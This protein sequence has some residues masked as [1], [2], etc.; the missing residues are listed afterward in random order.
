MVTLFTDGITPNSSPTG[1]AAGPD[2]ALWFTEGVV[3]RAGH[4]YL[5]KRRRQLRHSDP[6]VLPWAPIRCPKQDA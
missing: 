3:V 5:A 2:G 1:I 4:S 6:S